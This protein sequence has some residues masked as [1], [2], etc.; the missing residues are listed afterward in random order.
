MPGA[1][2][3]VER[4]AAILR[5]LAAEEESLALGQVASALALAKPTVHGL[6]RTLV[7]VGFVE[8]DRLSGRYAVAADLFRLGT[9]RL[10]V[11]ELRSRAM[12][13]TDSLAAHTGESAQLVAFRDGRAVI[14]H[15]VFRVGGT[16]QV[17]RTGAAV[18]LHAN[19]FGKVLAAFDP[20]AAR[21]AAAVPLAALTR[22]TVTDRQSWRLELA[23]VRTAG[24][25]GAVAEEEPDKAGIAAPVRD[26]GGYLLAAVGIEGSPDRLCDEKGHPRTALV[27]QVQRAA[28]SITRELSRS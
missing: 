22:R 14:A 10:D 6:I 2:Q 28:R 24:W 27:A 12:N 18:S 26:R 7:D 25:A 15:H 8:Q 13:W 3:S 11:N 1:V 16:D 4:A 20:V 17:V 9:A 21:A 23:R 19:A 5:L